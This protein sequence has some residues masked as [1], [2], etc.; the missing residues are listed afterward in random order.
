MQHNQWSSPTHVNTIDFQLNNTFL[1]K[2]AAKIK[3]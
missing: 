2:Q 1:Y 3:I